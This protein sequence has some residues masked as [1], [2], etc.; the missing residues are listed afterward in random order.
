LGLILSS[1]LDFAEVL[2]EL[3]QAFPAL[4]MTTNSVN[5]TALDTA[6]IQGHVDIV[7]LL[8]ETDASLA[9]IARNNGKTV[10]HSAARMGHVEVVRALLNK[11]PGIE[12]RTDKK[13]QTA[14]HMASK[15]QNAEIVVELLKP[16][17]SVIHIEDNKGNRPLHVATRKGNITVS[18]HILEIPLIFFTYSIVCILTFIQY[19]YF[20]WILLRT[21]ITS[22]WFLQA[23]LMMI[24]VLLDFFLK[25][26]HF[27]VL[28]CRY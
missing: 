19:I 22:V 11:D 2:K 8:L 10:L 7:S 28:T 15:G 1:F 6:A 24:A 13:G 20:G 27:E 14:L 16:D 23:F 4:A 9:R 25:K 17:A 3:L 26:I 5:A 21:K 18:D 12:L